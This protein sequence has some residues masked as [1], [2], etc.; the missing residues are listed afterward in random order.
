MLLDE[1]LAGERPDALVNLHPRGIGPEE[2][3]PRPQ[4][5]MLHVEQGQPGLAAGGEQFPGLGRGLGHAHQLHGAAGK[6]IILDV[7][8]DQSGFHDVGPFMVMLSGLRPFG[9]GDTTGRTVGAGLKPAPTAHNENESYNKALIDNS[10][11]RPQ[12][13]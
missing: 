1:G 6:V 7:D 5:D 12:P 2:G 9:P 11:K 3:G 4:S 8:Q 13:A 10:R